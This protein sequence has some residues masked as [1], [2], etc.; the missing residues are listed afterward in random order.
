LCAF[1]L[2]LQSGSDLTALLCFFGR[3]FEWHVVS[4]L[5]FRVC[6]WSTVDVCKS[7]QIESNQ[8]LVLWSDAEA[9]VAATEAV[10][11]LTSAISG[12]Q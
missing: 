9:R 7:N 10:C 1:S 8:V 6:V 5:F 11:V 4:N 2:G 12:G 3:G